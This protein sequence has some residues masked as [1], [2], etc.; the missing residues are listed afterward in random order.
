[1][2][3]AVSCEYM[4]ELD[5]A[6]ILEKKVPAMVLMERAA[7]FVAEE[8]KTYCA[9]HR[10]A[11]PRILAVCGS[12]NNGGDGIAVAR[13]LHLAGLQAEI[14][15]AGNPEKMTEQTALQWEIARNYHVPVVNNAKLSE[16]TIIVDALFG[17]GL[18]R[19]VEGHY[20][21]LIRRMN[22]TAAWKVA[23]D[24]PSGLCGDTG[25]EL[26]IAFR[27]DLTV[28]FAFLKRGLCLYP[29]R[30]L[31]G[32]VVVADIGI[33]ENKDRPSEKAAA[34]SGEGEKKIHAC[35]YCLE[36]PDLAL[37]KK[38]SSDGNKGTF[39][40]VLVVAGSKGMCGAAYLSA[41]AALG[42]GAGMVKLVTPE[43][44][45]IP[46]QTLLPEAMV[47]V[48]DREEADLDSLAWC[49]GIVIGPGLGTS[50]E[51]AERASWFL[52]KAAERQL[53]VILDAD[54][55][56]LLALHPEWKRWLSPRTVL[57]PHLGEM[58]RLSG[59]TIGELK[60]DLPGAAA[61]WARI[62]NCI[63]VLKDAGTVIA[64][65]DGTCFFNLSGNACMAVAGSGDVLSGILGAFSVLASRDQLFTQE[66]E[67]GNPLL[68]ASAFGVYLH[69]RA[70]DAYAEQYG[71]RGMRAGDLIT[72]IRKGIG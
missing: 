72:E 66:P 44:N 5:A 69:G 4:K 10:E 16:Y 70:G 40:K 50:Q 9:A 12:G 60:E 2:R 32:R 1:M 35:G 24:L 65:P 55:L 8:I 3:T 25:Q 48:P 14:C 56:N 38:R 59:K 13:I 36:N 33:Y 15:L 6:T 61:A 51:S 27:A 71:D 28:T 37:L 58:S 41:A 21:E 17:V 11:S 42:S 20:A 18:A 57:T 43:E 26:G 67:C 23:V 68:Y 64:G 7:L 31:A 45:R 54:G 47:S 46:L 22:E 19:P 39:G 63:L 34:V 62:N 29:G 52:Q 30:H 49:D 53:P